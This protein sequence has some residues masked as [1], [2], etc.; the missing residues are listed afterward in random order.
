MITTAEGDETKQHFDQVRA[1]ACTE[2][3][4]FYIGR[5]VPAAEIEKRVLQKCPNSVN[6]A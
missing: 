3:Q 4:G 6:A 2:A 5:P 1:E